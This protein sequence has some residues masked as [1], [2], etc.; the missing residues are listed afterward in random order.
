MHFFHLWLSNSCLRHVTTKNQINWPIFMSPFQRKLNNWGSRKLSF[1]FET[2]FAE[3]SR[4]ALAAARFCNAQNFYS[5]LILFT[6]RYTIFANV[7]LA[8]DGHHTHFTWRY[9]TPSLQ[10]SFCLA[11]STVLIHSNTAWIKQGFEITT[12]G[13]WL[14]KLPGNIVSWM[15]FWLI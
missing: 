7:I 3:M 2:S 12:K 5:T 1:A 10:I 14:F 15:A 13:F 6:W 8:I 4:F 9:S 11:I